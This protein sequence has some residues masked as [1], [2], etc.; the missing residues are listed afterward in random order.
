MSL[1]LSSSSQSSDSIAYFL[2]KKPLDE[3]VFGEITDAINSPEH[4]TDKEENF[5]TKVK[6]EEWKRRHTHCLTADM[7]SSHLCPEVLFNTIKALIQEKSR[8]QNLQHKRERTFHGGCGYQPLAAAPVVVFRVNGN[9]EITQ[10]PLDGKRGDKNSVVEG[11]IFFSEESKAVVFD[12][13]NKYGTVKPTKKYDKLLGE[14]L[15]SF[16]MDVVGLVGEYY[17]GPDE[18]TWQI[19]KPNKTQ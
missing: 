4:S 5:D 16:S 18:L 1:I 14:A 6:V 3:K 2:N 12:T 7:S 19:T 9:G 10:R 13:I 17:R 11:G 8:L 15:L